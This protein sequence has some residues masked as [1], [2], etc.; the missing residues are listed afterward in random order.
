MYKTIYNCAR[1]ARHARGRFIRYYFY[2]WL[3]TGRAPA[4]AQALSL[5]F[6]FAS[7]SDIALDETTNFLAMLALPFVGRGWALLNKHTEISQNIGVRT[8]YFVTE[9]YCYL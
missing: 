2:E 1:V 5:S 4:S 9:S 6:R 3:A 8:V 7:C